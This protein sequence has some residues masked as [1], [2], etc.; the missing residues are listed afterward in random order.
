[1]SVSKDIKIFKNIRRAS[2]DDISRIAEILVFS[3]RKN[4][5]HI[6]N[7]DVGSFV[8]LQVYPLVK[9]YVSRPELLNSIFVYDDEF[10]KGVMYIEGSEVKELYIEPFFENRGIGG[11]LIEFAKTRLD[12]Y[13]LWVLN[14]NKRAIKFYKQHG[15]CETSETRTVPEVPNLDVLE[16][17]MIRII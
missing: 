12:C 13:E 1:M 17:K 6:F 14:E 8:E 7:D 10:V 5:R 11:E 15:F 4:Y 9:R 2:I 16:T 3:K